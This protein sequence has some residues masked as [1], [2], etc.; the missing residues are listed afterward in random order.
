LLPMGIFHGVTC[1]PTLLERAGE[2]CTIKNLH[3]MSAKALQFT[4]EF[5]CQAWGGTAK[6]LYDCGMELS[7]PDRERIVVKVPVTATGVEGAALLV[8]A[9]CRVCLTASYNHKQAL[10]AANVGAEY[11]APYLGRMTD[12]GK[13]GAAECFKM[14]EIIQ[15]IEADTRVLV[16]SIRDCQTMI[17]LAAEGMETFTF[18]PAVARELFVEPMTKEAASE[19]EAAAARNC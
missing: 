17:D 10:I 1:N 19:F 12:A 8:R 11:I 3:K 4:D 18:S 13:D 2:P 16:A 6:E 5:M 9:N 14:Q 7:R 15:G